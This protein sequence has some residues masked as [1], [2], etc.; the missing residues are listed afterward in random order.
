MWHATVLLI[1]SVYYIHKI[2][3]HALIYKYMDTYFISIGISTWEYKKSLRQSSA[4]SAKRCG[5]GTHTCACVCTSVH[6]WVCEGRCQEEGEFKETTEP[7]VR[8]QVEEKKEGKLGLRK[9]SEDTVKDQSQWNSDRCALTRG[10]G[11]V[12]WRSLGS[13]VPWAWTWLED[14]L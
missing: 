11:L 5:M 8:V 1:Y 14:H 9:E 4:L 7:E 10:G 2:Y 12:C 3:V 13:G 6:T